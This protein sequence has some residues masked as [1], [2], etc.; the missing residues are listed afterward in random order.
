MRFAVLAVINSIATLAGISTG[1]A[2]AWLGFGYWSLLG[3][4]AGESVCRSVSVWLYSGW[5]PGMPARWGE[6]RGL[7]HTGSIVTINGAANH[8]AQS[9]DKVL[10]GRAYGPESLGLYTRAQQLIT[11]PV[12]LI[13]NAI[14]E[15][16]MSTLSRVKTDQAQLKA[17]FLKSYALLISISAP[18]A[19]LLGLLAEDVIHVLLGPKWLECVPIFR[20]L[21]P[22]VFVYAV[23]AP[24]FSL[25]I[26]CDLAKRSMYLGLAMAPIMI[27][28]Y[29]VGMRWGAVGAA[30]GLSLSMALWSVP[31]IAWTL[32][33][34]PIRL[35]EALLAI[36]RPLLAAAGA[37]M[38]VALLLTGGALATHAA[39]LRLLA[40]VLVFVV[41]YALLLLVGMRQWALFKD[42]LVTLTARA[43]AATPGPAKE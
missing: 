13:N 43:T 20:N 33:K 16:L 12:D 32:H 42:V 1:V 27:C 10:L 19:V 34:T 4:I 26:A 18:T 28:G 15:V 11:F 25:L 8:L 2:M 29:A 31:H 5:R 22:A 21:A 23:L 7:L 6:I 41:V 37:A 40:C 30:A 39:G 9:L 38:P 35:S 17:Y 24:S 36:G 14:G 3:V